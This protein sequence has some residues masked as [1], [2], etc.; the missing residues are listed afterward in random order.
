[1]SYLLPYC[2]EHG[3]VYSYE[4]KDGVTRCW[5]CEEEIQTYHTI[6]ED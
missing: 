3:Y 4:G 2:K 1:M 6:E 5:F